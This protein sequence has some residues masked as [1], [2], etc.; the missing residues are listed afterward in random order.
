MKTP[1]L[2]TKLIHA[3]EPTPRLLGAVSMPIFQSATFEYDG[4]APYHDLRYI[5]LSNTPTHA[6]LHGKL[7]AIEDAESAVATASGMAAISTTLLAFL[8]GGDHML[9]Q[10]AL[11]G[12]THDFIHRDLPALGITSTVIDAA[13]PDTWERALQ[14]RT[15]IMYVETLSNPLL[16][17]PHLPAVAKFAASH[18]LVTVIDNT[19]ASPVNHRPATWGFDLVVHSASKYLNGHSDIVAGA[20]MGRAE[21]VQ[22]VTHKLN[23]LGGC[24][25]PHACFLLQR[26]LKTLALRVRQQNHSAQVLARFLASQPSVARVHY[27]GLEG[28]PQ[29]AWAREWLAGFGGILSF[30][31]HGGVAAADALLGRLEL[32]VVAPSLGGVETLVTR[33]AQTSHADMSAED[34]QASGISDGLVRL[35]VGIESTQ[36]LLADFQHALTGG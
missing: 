18:G 19:F 11:Y 29:H 24:L 12:G 21:L 26:G 6:S 13:M 8:Q 28:H 17:V 15:K 22:R 33:P 4:G 25:D 9:V 36:D 14:P 32:P 20:V 3:G 34:R 30:E 23:H 31:M 16:E 5:R 7:A 2:E 27:P 10:R 1:S 35:S